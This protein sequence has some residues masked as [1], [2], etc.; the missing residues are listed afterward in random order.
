MD[1]ERHDQAG[2]EELL[3]DGRLGAAGSDPAPSAS[4]PRCGIDQHRQGR[5]AEGW[6]LAEVNDQERLP[7]VHSV[8]ESGLKRRRG[9]AGRGEEMDGRDPVAMRGEDAHHGPG[10][11]EPPMPD[12]EALAGVFGPELGQHTRAFA[13]VEGSQENVEKVASVL[14]YACPIPADD[15]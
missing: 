11:T 14:H 3:E 10:R 12:Y 8:V 15:Q 6:H 9:H 7:R 2:G 13:D 5:L 4:R 1:V